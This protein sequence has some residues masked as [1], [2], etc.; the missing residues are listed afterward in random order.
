MTGLTVGTYVF[1]SPLYFTTA[2][3]LLNFPVFG[4]T[5]PA[6]P[7]QI[8]SYI[9][10]GEIMDWQ[11]ENV[12]SLQTAAGWHFDPVLDL[13]VMCLLAS[14]GTNN[15]LGGIFDVDSKKAR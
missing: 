12:A 9:T 10:M 7:T 14:C 1:I 15:L 2:S 13:P 5:L 8:I 3:A 4:G 11:L 6:T